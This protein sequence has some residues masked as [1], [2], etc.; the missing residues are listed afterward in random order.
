M[1]IPKLENVKTDTC[2]LLSIKNEE[3][4]KDSTDYTTAILY[5]P[6]LKNRGRNRFKEWSNEKPKSVECLKKTKVS[7]L[8]GCLKHEVDLW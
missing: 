6:N 5:K 7:F 4:C 2:Y 1:P 8:C 3:P